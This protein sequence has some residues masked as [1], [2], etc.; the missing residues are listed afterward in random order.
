[1]ERGADLPRGDLLVARGWIAALVAM[2]IY[3]LLLGVTVAFITS[4]VVVTLRF[5]GVEL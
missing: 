4:A 3:A 2:A 5:L 1:M